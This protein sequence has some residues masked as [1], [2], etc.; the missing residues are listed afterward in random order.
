[1]HEYILADKILQSVLDFMDKQ[2]LTSVSLVDVGVGELLGLERNS[3]NIAYG[4]LSKGTKA[5]GS[6]L[7]VHPVKGIV[8]CSKCGFEGR[9][10]H[11]HAQ[12]T[13]DPVFACPDCGSSVS[14]KKGN[15][16]K[17]NRIY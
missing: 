15:E 4:I 13:V 1:M 9:L 11:I 7:K 8:S 14:I 6:R 12:H 3:L 10:K 2:S 16:V 5:E 17:L